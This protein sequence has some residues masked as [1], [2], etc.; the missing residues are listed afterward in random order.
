MSMSCPASQFGSR[1]APRSA[2]EWTSRGFSLIEILVVL[3]IIVILAA[4][5][6]PSLSSVN[7]V[8]SMAEES[9][10]A[11]QQLKAYRDYSLDNN[12]KIMPGYW[13]RYQD[14]NPATSFD[15]SSWPFLE[16]RDDTGRVIRDSSV[17]GPVSARYPWRLGAYM[18]Y[19]LATMFSGEQADYY[20]TVKES[21]EPSSVCYLYTLSLYPSLGL[22]TMWL[23][24]DTNYT[25]D[26]APSVEAMTGK[27]YAD[28]MSEIRHPAKLIVFASAHEVNHSQP[29]ISCV[30]AVTTASGLQAG[31]FRVL[32]PIWNPLS[33]QN[34]WEETYDPLKPDN[35]GFVATRDGRKVVTGMI[36]GSVNQEPIDALRDMRRWAN[37]ADS[38]TWDAFSS[39]VP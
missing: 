7:S 13:N 10:A 37:Q 4:I 5:V 34:P 24:G 33:G 16:A 28:R 35:H 39:L 38:P 12:G 21:L 14:D 30:E 11:R 25:A 19:R 17:A 31:N 2:T 36:D 26:L 27:L 29:E 32:S 3:G 6:L 18:D 1:K 9:T 22:N 15:E 8:A 20:N 23:G